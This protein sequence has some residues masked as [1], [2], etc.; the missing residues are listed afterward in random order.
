MGENPYSVLPKNAF[1]TTGVTQENPYVIEG[2]YKKKFNISANTKIATAGSC[3][4]R[5]ISRHLNKNVYNVLDV[6][7]PPRGLPENFHQKYGFSMYS[8][9]YGNIYR[10][11]QLLQLA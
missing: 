11:R 1:W 3:F 2:I 5:H 8:T 7:L 4:A 9:R 10:V 6:E